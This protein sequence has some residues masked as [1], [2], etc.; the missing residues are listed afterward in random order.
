MSQISSRYAIEYSSGLTGDYAFYAKLGRINSFGYRDQ[1]WAFLNSYFFSA[2]R[3]DGSL[4]SQINIYGGS[5]TDGLAYNGLPFDYIKDPAKR[6]HNYS[7]FSYDSDGRTVNWI[8]QRRPQD[9]ENFSQPQFELLNDWKISDNLILKS[10]LF[11][12]LGEGY[13]DYDGTGW[14]DA[15]SFRLTPENGFE[16]AEDP[17]NPI[18]RAF[19][20]NKYGGWIPR[21]EIKHTDGMLMVG[22]EIRIHRSEHC[23]KI[24]Y[25]ENL[26]E[27]YNPDYNFYYYDGARNIFS[28]FASE[29]YNINEDLSLNAEIQ[30][31]NHTYAIENE[32]AGNNFTRYQTIDGSIKG[33][34]GRIFDVNYLF[35]NPRFGMNYNF[36]ENH[37]AYFSVALTSREPRMNNL[38]N[39]SESWTGSVPLFEKVRVD[40]ANVRYNFNNPLVKPEQML[41]FELG[42]D[43]S[44]RLFKLN[45]NGYWMEYYDELVKSGQLDNFGA[46]IDGNAPK[47]RHYGVEI[48]GSAD[49]FESN[50]YGTLSFAANATFS[51]NYI[52]E[53]YF[54]KQPDEETFI[55]DLKD[56]PISGFPDLMAFA[57]ISYIYKDF[58]TSFQLK[59]VGEFRTDNF[60]DMLQNNSQL[61]AALGSSYYAV[62]TVKP[63]TVLNADFSYTFKKIIGVNSLKLHFHIYNLTNELYASTGFGAEFYPAAE[64][65]FFLGFELGL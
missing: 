2:M 54:A 56:N 61:K 32:K 40:S 57:R 65:N 20:K 14:T 45:V 47:T 30:L 62:N 19:V 12:K 35:F 27:N 21:L 58:F 16:N 51:K 8:T 43:Y 50:I 7:Y 36:N 63:Y 48:L 52:V 17:R 34:G 49:I 23:G 38:Y 31:V 24:Q 5:Q 41:N 44:S 42:W 59:H 39:A 1:S 25:A 29:N 10:S 46:P 18:I 64:R 22:S 33:N 28:V 3:F 53:Y 9:I 4:T 13:F 15:S 6:R 55:F 37:R 60:G 26:P 11:F